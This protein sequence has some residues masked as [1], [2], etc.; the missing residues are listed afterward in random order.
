MI[1]NRFSDV[2]LV[3]LLYGVSKLIWNFLKTPCIEFF[4]WCQG[5]FKVGSIMMASF[6][7]FEHF[8]SVLLVW[9]TGA[10]PWNCVW[11]FW[12]SLFKSHSCPS[13][14]MSILLPGAK[15][16]NQIWPQ[17]SSVNS[18]K[19]H[20]F[21]MDVYNFVVCWWIL[22][23]LLSSINVLCSTLIPLHPYLMPSGSYSKGSAALCWAL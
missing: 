19:R 13:C 22:P 20:R 1:Q 4:Q 7:F 2:T 10:G 11:K 9:G 14:D 5:C 21:W 12:R 16:S 23:F 18:A 3:L 8:Q 6:I 15:S 17:E